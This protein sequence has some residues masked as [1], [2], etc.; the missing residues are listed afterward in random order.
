MH[1][2]HHLDMVVGSHNDGKRVKRTCN[3]TAEVVEDEGAVER[4][5]HFLF[6]DFEGDICHHEV[7]GA[8]LD[9]LFE[10]FLAPL[11]AAAAY[12]N[13]HSYKSQQYQRRKRNHQ[14]MPPQ[15]SFHDNCKRA[16]FRL[17]AVGIAALNHKSIC[18]IIEIGEHSLVP[19]ANVHPLVVLAVVL[20]LVGILVASLADIIEGGKLDDNGL[21]ALAVEH[22]FAGGFGSFGGEDGVELTLVALVVVV[23][24]HQPCNGW[25]WQERIDAY[26]RRIE[27][28]EPV[29]RAKI[30][31]AGIVLERR[32]LQKIVRQH[33]V[34][35]QV[36]P[37]Y[38]AFL[39]V[40]LRDAFRRGNPQVSGLVVADNALDDVAQKPAV[41]I[42]GG[43]FASLDVKQV[44]ARVGGDPDAFLAIDAKIHHP[45]V[46]QG[47]GVVVVALVIGINAAVGVVDGKSLIGANEDFAIVFGEGDSPDACDGRAVGRVRRRW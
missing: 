5:L 40:E 17:H 32:P 25:H 15:R 35:R 4:L 34:R 2:H 29:G 20:E 38:N 10:V 19:R 12:P 42:V 45:I 24:E 28:C 18:A 21:A 33:S 1:L 22:N 37:Y 3:L 14:W 26:L 8:F 7:F 31:R 47:G 9:G 44:E 30:H 13:Q 46:A 27:I 6:L 43:E 23:F 11:V 41:G 39:R 16:N 36:S